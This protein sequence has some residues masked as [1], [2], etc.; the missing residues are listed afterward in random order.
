MFPCDPAT[1]RPI[2]QLCLNGL[3]SATR[4]API[5][6]Q[7]W[8][9]RPNAMIGAQMGKHAKVWA[10]DLDVDADKGLDGVAALERLCAERGVELPDTLSQT[11]PRGGRHLLFRWEKGRPVRNSAHKLAPGVD[12]R[13]EG[14]YIILAPSLRDDGG[15]Y[16][17]GKRA[18]I[19]AAPAWLYEAMSGDTAAEEAAAAAAPLS[20]RAKARGPR[21]ADGFPNTPASSRGRAARSSDGGGRYAEA[22]LAK[23]LD[24]VRTAP[25]GQRNQRL[26][27]AAFNLGQLVGGGQLDESRVVSDLTGAAQLCGYVKEEGAQHTEAVIFSGL[28]AGKQK[29]RTP[30]PS[31]TTTD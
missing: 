20:Q 16:R 24:S 25:K 30:H 17:W 4:W 19:A 6:Q 3:Y 1:K 26:N 14:G 28:N 15:A 31:T 27:T 23:E 7:W 10:L 11:T 8:A 22:A 29:P 21:D 2:N 9:F 18:P 13:G 5:I 12:V